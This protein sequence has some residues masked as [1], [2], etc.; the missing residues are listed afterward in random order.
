MTVTEASGRIT[1]E[2][3]WIPLS[4]ASQYARIPPDL[5]NFSCT[6][7]SLKRRLLA[8]LSRQVVEVPALGL[9][10][11][12][13]AYASD[14]T[15][16]Y[17]ENGFLFEPSAQDHI[18]LLTI[19]EVRSFEEG[20]TP[21]VAGEAAFIFKAGKNNYGHLLVEMLPKLE[22]LYTA[23]LY[24]IPL[25]VP[26]LPAAIDTILISVLDWV[27]GGWPLLRLETPLIQ[28]ERLVYPSPVAR[29]GD[30]KSSQVSQFA[31]RVL[32]CIPGSNNVPAT[33]R[34]YIS[35]RKCAN[36]ALLNEKEVEETFVRH[37][38]TIFHPEDHP[39]ADQVRI[40]SK[41]TIVAGPVGAALTSIVFAPRTAKVLVLDPG[42]HDIFFFDLACL[43][44]QSFAWLF[45]AQLKSPS[46]ATLHESWS[47]RLDLVESVLCTLD[48]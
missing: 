41:A 2:R 4:D 23:G 48:A 44:G 43:R 33:A 21:K 28:V 36:R 30:C 45:A 13:N 34:L 10:V 12:A 7:P 1:T 31:D 47:I 37:G 42:T 35:R 8:E 38:F 46:L 26:T 6:D 3:G 24:R 17:E 16:I 39:F 18:H 22:S 5:H 27:Y 20:P 25:L 14:L 15:F 29:H 19:D 9:H 11:L 32:A 40:F